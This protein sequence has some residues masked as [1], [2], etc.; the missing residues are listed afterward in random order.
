MPDILHQDPNLLRHVFPSLRVPRTSFSE[1]ALQVQV[2]GR[3]SC[4]DSTLGLG[5]LAL[6]RVAPEVAVQIHELLN[7]L[8]RK[9]GLLGQMELALQCEADREVLAA[10]GEHHAGS[11]S[12]VEPVAVI[13]PLPAAARLLEDCDVKEVGVGLA[14][15]DFS[16]C[17]AGFGTRDEELELVLRTFDACLEAGVMPRLDLLDVTR[18]DIAAVALPTIERCL[19][20][21]SARSAG[22]LRVRLCDTLGVG[23]PWTEAPGPRSIPRL[24]HIVRYSLGLE[25]AQLEFSGANDLGLVLANSI[26]GM[27]H[28][29]GRIATTIGGVAERAGTAATELCLVH[30]SGLFGS[31]CDLTAVPALHELLGPL[32]FR[33]DARYPLWGEQALTTGSVH[34]CAPADAGRELMAPFDAATQLQREPRL[35]LTLASGPRAVL[36]LIKQHCGA[37]E[38]RLDDDAVA[39]IYAW[40]CEQGSEEL[41]WEQIEPAVREHLPQLLQG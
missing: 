26:A 13:P 3:A 15:S 8:S 18:S 32:G 25:P 34:T 27:I 5:R 40:A 30:L 41:S 36:C 35:E 10:V 16:M 24:I 29:C 2:P 1:D 4:V 38:L 17:M 37:D 6:G 21:L 23:L 12:Q 7:Q 39:A 14:I 33:P 9:S 19:E 28:G 31:A 11:D 20:H 22:S